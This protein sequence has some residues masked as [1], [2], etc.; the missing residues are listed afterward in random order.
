MGINNLKQFV[1][2]AVTLHVK[3]G[4]TAKVKVYFVDEEYEDIVAAV[5]KTSR[6]EHYRAP[7][8][9]HTLPQGTSYLPNCRSRPPLEPC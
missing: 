8:A 3:D 9:M 2:R 7:C 1:D 6:P 4:E 5:V